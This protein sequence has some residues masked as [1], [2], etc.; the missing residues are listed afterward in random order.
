MFNRIRTRTQIKPAFP[1]SRS[2]RGC[3]KPSTV[4]VVVILSC[5][6]FI[7]ISTYIY[8]DTIIP[9]IP[10]ISDYDFHQSNVGVMR[11]I[12][13]YQHTGFVFSCHVSV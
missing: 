2:T 6:L 12:F 3:R 9:D 11:K 5:C 4:G 1:E 7:Y 10:C 13:G 8:F